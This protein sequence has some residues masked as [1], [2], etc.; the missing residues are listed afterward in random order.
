[1]I[2]TCKGE[3]IFFLGFGII[4]KFYDLMLGKKINKLKGILKKYSFKQNLSFKKKEIF[5]FTVQKFIVKLVYSNDYLNPYTN[6]TAFSKGYS[7]GSYN[8]YILKL[9]AND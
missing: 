7:K 1:M 2:K 9:L 6:L 5:K 8:N 4:N 3:I